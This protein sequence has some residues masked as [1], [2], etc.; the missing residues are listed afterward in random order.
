MTIL[1]GLLEILV[2]FVVVDGLGRALLRPF[3]W[4]TDAPGTRAVS[5]MLGSVGISVVAFA[6]AA[7]GM[8]ST[9]AAYAIAGIAVLGAATGLYMDREN[10]AANLTRLRNLDKTTRAAMLAVAAL[11][12]PAFFFALAPTTMRDELV[13]HLMFPRH[14]L[15]T[16]NL[17]GIEGNFYTHYPMGVEMIYAV[18]LP[19]LG[20]VGCRLYHL[21]CLVLSGWTIFELAAARTSKRA[22]A[23]AAVALVASPTAMVF[24]GA[25][26]VDLSMTLVVLAAVATLYAWHRHGT[27]CLRLPALLGLMGGW[28]V[29]TR[30]TGLAYAGL[31]AIWFLMVHRGK[32]GVPLM[33]GFGVFAAA[34]LAFGLPFLARN[35]LL[36]GNPVY[37]LFWNVLGGANWDAELAASL[38]I[39]WSQFG[40]GRGP[41]GMLMLPIN[42]ALFGKFAHVA[43]GG[44]LGPMLLLLVVG[45]VAVAVGKAG[46]RRD[47]AFPG[48]G[49]A[50]VMACVLFAT[51]PHVSRLALPAMAI[52]AVYA[53]P[54]FDKAWGDGGRA[55]PIGIAVIAAA[56]AGNLALTGLEYARIQPFAVVVGAEDAG[57]YMSRRIQ[58][59]P[60]YKFINEKL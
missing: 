55:R 48:L 29:S 33:P 57:A 21:L 36:T 19:I 8:F 35:F 39:W 4:P 31:F 18:L 32:D 1:L 52:L 41:V 25:A 11:S 56:L 59:W 23:V 58:G 54:A 45:A 24:A 22:A 50:T 10:V 30:Y 3:R 2:L 46:G 14:V 49:I 44:S 17:S 12:I 43:F 27:A 28:C 16:G 9:A 38:K 51:G 26:Y 53:A 34:G 40:M 20:D 7:I 6:A 15:E 47:D 42:I 37:P 60:V 5:F 13:Y